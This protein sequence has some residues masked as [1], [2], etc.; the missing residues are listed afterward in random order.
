MI[1]TVKRI[2]IISEHAS[3]ITLFGGVDSG[4]QNVYVGQLAKNLALLGYE[5]DVFTR[6]DNNRL[7]KIF[8]WI[9]G[10]RIIHVPAGPPEFIPKEDLF[11]YMTQ[12]T[13]YTARFLKNNKKYDIIHANFWMSGFVAM[14]LKRS[15]GIPFV[16]TFHALGHVRRLHQREADKFPE[17]RSMIEDCIMKE[18][19]HIIAECPQDKE[20]M[21][22]FYTH[23]KPE[24]ITI[25]PCGFDP[26]ELWPMKKNSARTALWFKSDEKL[27]LHLGRMVPRKGVDNVIYGFALCIKNYHINARLII[28][29]GETSIP[30]LFIQSPEITRLQ[31]IASEEG[32]SDKIYFTGQLS[33]SE[34]KYYYSAADMFV[35]TPWYEPFGITP[36]EAMACGTTVI[37]SNVGGIKYTVVDGETGFLVSTHC[38]KELSERMVY[39]Y[40]RPAVRNIFQKQAIKRANDFFTWERVV[41]DIATLYKRVLPT[42]SVRLEEEVFSLGDRKLFL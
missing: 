7:P 9:K 33:R 32:I 39:L 16:I 34:L 35:T 1:N 8:P 38:P 21:I 27:I 13:E 12:F 30:E 2:A 20:D 41:A 10:V 40:K 29:G 31:R 42:R 4:G 5:V 15:L 22:H 23:A 3:P 24:K 14:N 25:I 28:G 26:S 18:A 36:I 11:P 17:I 37:G 6:R 19:D